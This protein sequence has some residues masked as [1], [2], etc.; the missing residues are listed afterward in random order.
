M[1]T[2]FDVEH[3][4]KIAEHDGFGAARLDVLALAIGDRRRHLAEL[5]RERAAESA[6][7]LA[8]GHLLQ[9][10]AR[11]RAQQ[12]SRLHFHAELTQPGA[13]VVVGEPTGE[14][15]V[16][17]LQ[18]QHIDQERREFV[19]ALRQP[20]DAREHRRLVAKQ[21]GV[22]RPDHP[23]A[24]AG[25][26]HQVVARLEL[27][28]QLDRQGTRRSAVAGIETGLTAAG[29]QLG[30]DHVA[31]GRLEQLER[32]ESDRWPH[33]IDE[34]GDE[35]ADFHTFRGPRLDQGA[36]GKRTA[37]R[38]YHAPRGHRP[39]R[40]IGGRAVEF[41]SADS[42]RAPF[43][44]VGERIQEFHPGHRAHDAA[45]RYPRAIARHR[46]AEASVADLG[47]AS[48]DSA[49]HPHGIDERAPGR[50]RRSG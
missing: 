3:A 48:V 31:A 39:D 12:A 23:R 14:V 40:L 28:D 19:S 42:S 45:A 5:D 30:H 21:L 44:D 7:L 20:L 13:A 4:A 49:S 34:T 18:F 26:Q 11:Q 15:A 29:L 35:Q 46:H 22:M 9:L 2:P 27:L 41:L 8:I 37:R 6:A 43:R 50:A 47:P 24:R 36:R 16:G 32:R 33:Q 17:A 38:S 10:Y 1:Q 25:G